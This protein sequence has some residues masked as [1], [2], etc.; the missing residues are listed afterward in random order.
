MRPG[1]EPQGRTL[2]S[3]RGRPAEL[4]VVVMR[5]GTSRGPVLRSG[6]LPADPE[7]RD[8]LLIRLVGGGDTQEDGI[9]GGGPATSKVVVVGIAEAST[10]HVDIDYA[11][12]N[13]VLGEG[14]IDWQGTCGNMTAAVPLFA[15]EEQLLGHESP[16]GI[17]L[18]NLSTGQLVD[19]ELLDDVPAH[20]PGEPVVIRTTYLDPGAAVLPSALPTGTPRE[21]LHV[22]GITYQSSIVDVA[23]PYL[24]LHHQAVVGGAVLSDPAVIERIERI[25]AAACVRLGLVA[26]TADAARLSPSVPRVILIDEHLGSPDQLRVM[27]VS[28]GRPI[29]TVP[30]TAALCLSAARAMPG[31]LVN[32]IFDDAPQPSTLLV[33][34]PSAEITASAVVNADGRVH[35]ASVERTARSI[36]HGVALV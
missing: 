28:M 17:R 3:A 9:G 32:Q 16:S 10:E 20:R 6:D 22:D 7:D 15:I 30:V 13:I 33:S 21:T 19:T 36:L 25:R 8:D 12:G 11:V 5:G 31:T 1:D 23:H 14:L 4:R 18:R 34:G 26:S 2:M 35:S 29:A 24:M 27:A